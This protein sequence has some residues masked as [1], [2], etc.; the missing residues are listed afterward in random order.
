MLNHDCI[1][2]NPNSSS[3]PSKSIFRTRETPTLLTVHK[4]SNESTEKRLATLEG[5]LALE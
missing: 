4:Q 5:M 2:E 3:N 1:N